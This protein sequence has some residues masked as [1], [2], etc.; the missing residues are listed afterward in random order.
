MILGILRMENMYIGGVEVDPHKL[1]D[2]GLRKEMVQHICEL[3]NAILQFDFSAET[4]TT[5]SMIKNQE[6]AMKSLSSLSKRLAGFQNALTCIED[7]IAIDG[8][9]ILREEMSRII[10]YNVE[11]EVN[12]YLLKK[13]LD[14]DSKFQSKIVPI[15]RFPKT[16]NEPSCINF[17]GRVISMLIKITETQCTTYSPEKS[18]WH[19]SE[20]G[21]E[22]CNMK[23]VSL[24]RDAIGV[25]GLVGIDRLLSYRILHEAHRFVKFY[26]TNV[27]KHNVLFE[28]LRDKVRHVICIISLS[29]FFSNII[30]L[31]MISSSQ[32]GKLLVMRSQS[33]PMV[34]E[35][36]KC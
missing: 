7:F 4:E 25:H 5:A 12:K 34:Q 19:I 24:L 13:V 33:T 21:A 29:S 3:M 30:F 31:Q 27:S 18:G 6:S 35:R 23:T 11:Q 17:M 32:S 8:S 36:Q 10:S 14:S 16:Q 26:K 20:H 28:Q 1:I 15:P 22:V 2:D 9:K